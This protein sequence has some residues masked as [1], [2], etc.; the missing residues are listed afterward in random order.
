[1]QI[2]S[3]SDSSWEA[4]YQIQKEAYK[5]L[6][7]EDID[8]LKSK[9]LIAPQMCLMCQSESGDILAY[10]LAHPWN[11]TTPPKLNQD[12]SLAIRGNILFIHDLAVSSK[13]KG[14]GVGKKMVNELLARA[15][16]LGLKRAML[17]SVQNSVA[18]WSRFGFEEQESDIPVEYGQ[19]ARLM[20]MS[21]VREDKPLERS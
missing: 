11:Q 16:L 19:G 5:D 15:R 10:L 20:S 2:V 8:V 17:V 13:A 9:W 4:V 7:H 3:L 21:L 1:M 12:T 18:F 6:L 14:M